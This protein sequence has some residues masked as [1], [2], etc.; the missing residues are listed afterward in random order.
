[1]SLKST[2]HRIISSFTAAV[3]LWNI[4]GWLGFGLILD[5]SH[6]HGEANHCE[7]TFCYCEIG[8]GETICTCHHGDMNEHGQHSDDHGSREKNDFCYYSASDAD[9]NTASQALIV[10]AKF[11]ALYLDSDH[12]DRPTDSREFDAGPITNKLPGVIPDLLR[13]PRI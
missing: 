1:M 2:Y 6:K 5:H 13:P 11:N 4:V 9:A 10:I 12:L 7:V 3:M 8:E